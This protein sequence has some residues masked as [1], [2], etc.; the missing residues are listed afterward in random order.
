M[1]LQELGVD[2]RQRLVQFAPGDVGV[3]LVSHGFILTPAGRMVNFPVAGGSLR[4]AFAYLLA[5]FDHF[6][7]GFGVEKADVS[8]LHGQSEVSGHAVVEVAPGV[9]S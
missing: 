3:V 8:P 7:T 2:L 9:E 6:G 1:G 5:E 4:Y